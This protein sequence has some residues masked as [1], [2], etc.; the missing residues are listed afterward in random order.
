MKRYISAATKKQRTAYIFSSTELSDREEILLEWAEYNVD[1][2]LSL[3]EQVR[4]A[5]KVDCVQFCR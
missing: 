5:E 1:P 3:Q 4:Q 2:D